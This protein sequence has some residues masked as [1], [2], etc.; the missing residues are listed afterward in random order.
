MSPR[1]SKI[2]CYLFVFVSVR[3]L[4]YI[5]INSFNFSFLLMY[6]IRTFNICPSYYFS[7]DESIYG[8]NMGGGSDIDGDGNYTGRNTQ[9]RFKSL[10]NRWLI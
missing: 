10:V 8:D 7:A 2:K 3:M 5:I 4:F 9:S 6:F 1:L